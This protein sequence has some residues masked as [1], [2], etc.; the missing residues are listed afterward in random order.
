MKHKKY[1]WELCQT[2][3]DKILYAG[4]EILKS[5]KSYN[6]QKMN[7]SDFDK[8]NYIIYHDQNFYYIGESKNLSARI[9]QHAHEKKSTFYKNYLK[10]NND[11]TSLN[12]SDFNIKFINTK[13]GRKEF[14]EFGIVNLP[15]TLN[16]FQKD[17]RSLFTGSANNSYWSD[18]QSHANKLLDDGEKYFFNHKYFNW[19]DAHPTKNAGVYSVNDS[20]DRLIYIGESSNISDRYKAHSSRTYFS[21]LRRHIGTEILNFSLKSINGKKRYFSDNEDSEI[22]NYLSE[23]NIRYMNVSLGR[24]ELEEYLIKKYHPLLNRRNDK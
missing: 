13:I 4:L 10:N 24:F 14:E 12:I 8:G 16:K 19:Y 11:S 18:V 21:A 17:K 20:N 22:N 7:H 15:A 2:E 23:C 5:S 6:L 9:S 3:S 1:N